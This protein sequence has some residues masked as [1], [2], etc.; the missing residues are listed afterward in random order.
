VELPFKTW[1]NQP[2]LSQACREKL[3]EPVPGDPE[4]RT[5]AQA[6]ADASA[7]QPT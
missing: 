7:V 2:A 1:R 6:I 3:S 4:G 5:Y